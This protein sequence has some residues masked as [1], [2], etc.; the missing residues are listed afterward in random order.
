MNKVY[1]QTDFQC[2][3]VMTLGSPFKPM[4]QLIMSDYLPFQTAGSCCGP[5]QLPAFGR[6]QTTTVQT[7]KF[8]ITSL[9]AGL[10]A[11]AKFPP[12]R[13]TI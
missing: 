8:F 2:A 7:D 6:H 4:L 10:L 5:I 1:T 9:L 12:E 3:N 13:L 11:E